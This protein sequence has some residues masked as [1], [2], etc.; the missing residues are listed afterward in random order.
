MTAAKQ[1]AVEM[2]D[3]VGIPQARTRVDSYPHEFSGGMRQRAMIAMSIIND[4]ELII[5]DEP[6]TALDVT[7]QAQ[8]LET[9]GRVQGGVQHGDHPDHPRPRRD[10]R[11]GRPGDGDVR[12]HG[13]SRRASSTT[14]TSSRGCRTPSAC[15]AR[16]PTID[17]VG[18]LTPIQGAPP[19]LINVPPGCP[20]SPR[21]PLARADCVQ[22][23]PALDAHRHARSR[24]RLPATGTSWSP[25]TTAAELFGDERGGRAVSTATPSEPAPSRTAERRRRRCSQVDDLVKHF[26]I[27]GGGLDPPRR[28]RGARRVRRVASTSAPARRSASWASRARGKTTTGPGRAAAAQADVGLGALRRRRAHR[29]STPSKMRAMRRDMQIV[30]QDPY[31]S[32]NPKMPVNDI[33]AEPLQGARPVRQARRARTRS[34]R[35]SSEVGLRPRARQ[36]LPARV[37]RRSAPARRHRPGAR[38]RTRASW[39]STSRCRRSTSA[40][41]PASSTCSRELQ[42]RLGAGVPVRRPRP[43][44]GAPHLRPGGRDVPRQDRR[45]RAARRRSTTAP[46][47]RTRRRCCRPCRCPTRSSS[48]SAGGSCCTGDIPSPVDPPSGC[49]F[50]TRCWKAQE[51]CAVEEPRARRPGRTAIRWPATSP[52]SSRSSPTSPPSADGRRAAGSVGEPRAGLARRPDPRDLHVRAHRRGAPALGARRRP[53]G[54]VRRCRRRLRSA[55]PRPSGT[56]TGSR[57]CVALVWVFT[58]IALGLLLD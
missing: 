49:R 55:P 38:P 50:R 15:S 44:G 33:I 31:A 13:S 36:P 18:E 6:T 54:H 48:G 29:R 51:I 45:D 7:V 17:H 46:P 20:F 57:S 27:R 56:S 32:L 22:I 2:L 26:P 43:V 42:D 12:R 52:R 53:V 19:S 21:C 40:S 28:R 16:C 34:P 10:R 4:P 11:H 47:T 23:E 3:L 37:L 25:S 5:A 35:C 9:L 41:R 1:R 24:G 58:T 30:F 14:S 39:C 8:V